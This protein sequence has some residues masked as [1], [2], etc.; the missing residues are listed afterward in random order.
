MVN[1]V[2]FILNGE[3]RLIEHMIV[4]ER[5]SDRGMQYELY[6][7][8]AGPQEQHRRARKEITD[9]PD[10]DLDV[11]L[12]QKW[13]PSFTLYFTLVRKINFASSCVFRMK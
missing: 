2:H 3:C 8:T 9:A 7:E 1:Y 5:P 12:S 6:E 13:L 10:Y 11:R 4:R